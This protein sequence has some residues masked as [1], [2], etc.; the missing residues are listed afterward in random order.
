MKV[1]EIIIQKLNALE[2]T[3]KI[4]LERVYAIEST[5]GDNFLLEEYTPP[6]TELEGNLKNVDIE[7]L[8]PKSEA[9][10][11]GPMQFNLFDK[12]KAKPK[13]RGKYKKRGY[14]QLPPSIAREIMEDDKLSQ[15]TKSSYASILDRILGDSKNFE[16]AIDMRNQGVKS[17]DT[18][19]YI[20]ALHEQSAFTNFRTINNAITVAR[21]YGLIELVDKK[22][23]I[24]DMF[25]QSK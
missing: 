24:T 23:V 4:L 6:K 17:K 14:T 10:P 7:I 25:H 2:A 19:E 16:V 21:R 1:A 11:K 13:K 8:P 18:A 9:K 20:R 22:Y 15:S 3:N 5:L 12:P